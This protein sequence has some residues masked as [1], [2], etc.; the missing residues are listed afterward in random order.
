M[1]TLALPRVLRMVPGRARVHLPGLSR[2]DPVEL[3]VRLRRLDGLHEA[4]PPR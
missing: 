4:G 3:E 1:S 2:N